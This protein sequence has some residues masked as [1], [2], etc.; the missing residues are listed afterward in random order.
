MARPQLCIIIIIIVI[1]IIIIII[2]IINNCSVGPILII[3]LI[4][5]PKA[6]RYFF[7]FSEFR[8]E[9]GELK[10]KVKQEVFGCMQQRQTNVAIFVARPQGR[11]LRVILF[12]P[13]RRLFS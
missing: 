5:R 8:L 1:I 6:L 12:F 11:F 7:Y 9:T 4:F 3:T 13:D 2:I 10:E